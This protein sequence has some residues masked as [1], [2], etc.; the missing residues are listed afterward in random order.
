LIKALHWTPQQPIKRAIQRD[1]EAIQRWRDETWPELLRRARRERR[2]LIFEDES[3]FYLLPGVVKTY[4]PEGLT[5]VLREKQTGD[6]LSVIGGMSPE[7][8]VYTLV[9]PDPQPRLVDRV[10]QGE[11]V[12]LEE[13][14]A[15]VAGGGRVGDAVG[16]QDAEVDLVVAAELEVL[17]AQAAG[18]EIEGDVQDVVGF[19]V[20]QM[21]LEEVELAV[22][23]LEVELAVDLLDEAD[24]LR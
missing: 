20:G 13:A 16:P 4:A 8:R 15:E 7:G 11:D 18:E 3:G 5:P 23:L 9:R 19:V 14:A 21:P 6:H 17:D 10:H 2:T 12:G 1:D 22:D 24:L